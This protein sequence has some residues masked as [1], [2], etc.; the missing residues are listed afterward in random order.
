MNT[1]GAISAMAANASSEAEL[2]CLKNTRPSPQDRKRYKQHARQH[3][4]L[5][6]LLEGERNEEAADAM[7]EHL[8]ST[9]RN[10]AKLRGLLRG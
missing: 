4:E 10:I 9:L 7:R 5:L 3:L 6:E 1:H 8:Q 2:A